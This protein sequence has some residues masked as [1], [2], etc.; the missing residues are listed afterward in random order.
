MLTLISIPAAQTWSKFK[1]GGWIL[2]RVISSCLAPKY[3]LVGFL[4]IKLD[5]KMATQPA[6]IETSVLGGLFTI[7]KPISRGA[8]G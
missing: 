4:I 7:I 3:F 1:R 2:A 6:V 5:G 8:F